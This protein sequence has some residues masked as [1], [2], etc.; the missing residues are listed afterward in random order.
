MKCQMK[1]MAY[2]I[3]ESH[4][5]DNILVIKYF[6]MATNFSH[7]NFSQNPGHK[8]SF[9]I[10]SMSITLVTKPLPF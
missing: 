5:D 8:A 7:T 6:C 1:S 10:K 2:N 3:L 4:A 9:Q